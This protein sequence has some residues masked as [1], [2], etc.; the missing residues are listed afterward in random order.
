MK[1]RTSEQLPGALLRWVSGGLLCL[2]LAGCATGPNANPR[3]PWEPFNRQ[4]TEFNDAVDGAVLKPVATVYR[5]ITPD[6][7]RTGVSNFFENLRD[8]WSFINASLQLRPREAVE[9]FM[10]FNVNTF[11]GLAGVLD[12]AC[13]GFHHRGTRGLR[14]GPLGCGV[15]QFAVRAAGCGDAGEPV[16]GHHDARW[17]RIGQIQF[18]PRCVPAAP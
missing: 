8:G 9:N 4:V 3:D 15:A 13:G 10:R 1:N 6:P 12:I 17:G 2:V 11:F 14:A 7:V 16:A 5:D 18:H